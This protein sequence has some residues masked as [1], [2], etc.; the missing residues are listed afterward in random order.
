MSRTGSE[1]SLPH[2]PPDSPGSSV[3]SQLQEEYDEL[4]KYAV[5]HY[6]TQHVR[7]LSDE[8]SVSDKENLCPPGADDV[9][10]DEVEV[11]VTPRNIND[12]AGMRHNIGHSPAGSCGNH[13]SEHGSRAY[14][15]QQFSATHS[16]TLHSESGRSDMD[17]EH[18]SYD[19]YT[20]SIDPDVGRM[21]ALLDQWALDLKRNVLAEFSQS[22]I[23]L[24]ELSHQDLMK[25]KERNAFE[26]NRLLNELDSVKELL[27][28]YEVSIERKDQ[29]ISNLTH[30]MQK[31]RE[32]YE[33]A[34][35][36]SE[37]KIRHNDFKRE[38]FASNLARKHYEK[39]LSQ[40]VWYAWHSIIET[41]WKNRVERACQAKAQDVCRD[42]TDHYEVKLA[43][44]NEALEASRVEVSKL[45]K[46]R[47]R[48]EEAMKKAFMRGVCALNLE[49]MS[50][51]Q[52]DEEHADVN[53]H[54][55]T[56]SSSSQDD[57]S[58]NLDG[59]VLEKDHGAPKTIPQE[60]IYTSHPA[61]YPPPRV[62]TSQGSRAVTSN[63]PH[64]QTVPSAKP[65]TSSTSSSKG[66]VISTKITARVDSGRPGKSILSANS[67]TLAPPMASVI[68][69]RHQ[70]ITKQTIGHA[71]ASKYPKPQTA[72]PG[73]IFKRLAGQGAPVTVAPHIQTVKVV[74]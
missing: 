15:P 42:L 62:I 65:S 7:H 12:N 70:P 38:A 53:Q 45:M 29:V 19:I 47:E 28:T 36:F 14:I 8:C 1:N 40:K 69:E 6:L 60:A 52:G 43:S 57:I 71:T 55:H 26:K 21:E 4:L 37:W 5:V 32:K 13:V 34:K 67:Q 11:V 2:I 30:A 50:M 56:G 48:Y 39:K 51:F 9:D 18:A 3:S 63:V 44:L 33:M 46:E 73:H 74:D 25:E 54:H 64:A 61:E 49:A 31:Q 72:P 23:R 16:M 10:A 35:K 66:K 68:V 20:A 58:D 27:H 22:K 59:G 24:I 41:R 17:R